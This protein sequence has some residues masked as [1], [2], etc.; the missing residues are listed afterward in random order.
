[1]IPAPVKVLHLLRSLC[2]DSCHKTYHLSSGNLSVDNLIV[3]ADL[4][5]NTLDEPYIGYTA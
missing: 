2:M 3:D 4:I 1:M 5:V